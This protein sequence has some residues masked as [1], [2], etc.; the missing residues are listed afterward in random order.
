MTMNKTTVLVIDN[1]QA[2]YLEPLRRL[3]ESS[4]NHHQ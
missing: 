3:P 1:P 2:D 4:E